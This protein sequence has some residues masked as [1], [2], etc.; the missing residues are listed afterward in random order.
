MSESYD[1]RRRLLSAGSLYVD[2]DKDLKEAYQEFNKDEQQGELKWSLKGLRAEFKF[3]GNDIL[4]KYY[5]SRLQNRFFT[6]LLMLNIVINMIDSFFIFYFK[7][8]SF[9]P[10]LD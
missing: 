3:K 8:I 7:V 10:F 2:V 4:Y 1:G 6:I 9:Q 5:T